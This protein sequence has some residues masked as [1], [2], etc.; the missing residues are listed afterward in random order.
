MFDAILIH[1]F[2]LHHSFRARPIKLDDYLPKPK[3]VTGS[4]QFIDHFNPTMS[5]ST[6][7]KYC[8][9]LYGQ[10][11]RTDGVFKIPKLPAT[12]VP[13]HQ[14]KNTISGSIE[15]ISSGYHSDGFYSIGMN[16]ISKWLKK[17]RLHKYLW[18]FE[19]VSYEKMFTFTEEYFESL[20][21]TLGARRKLASCID[22]LKTRGET[23]KQMEW[24]LSQNRMLLPEAITEM[25]TIAVSPMKPMRLN[26]DT[27]VGFQLWKLL[28]L[29]KD[30]HNS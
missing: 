17:L 12:L 18:V 13:T 19:N 5:F 28:N 24:D 4:N 25:E 6:V 2:F 27:D 20:N 14:R 11:Q 16:D 26:C 22:K 7:T 29:G 9:Y 3:E 15:S 8:G 10:E 23:M 1:N 21:I 30:K